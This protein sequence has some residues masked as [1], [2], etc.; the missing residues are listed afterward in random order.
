M[1]LALLYW[2]QAARDRRPKISRQWLLERENSLAVRNLLYLGEA[3]TS[4]SALLALERGATSM[5]THLPQPR[6][7]RRSWISI[8]NAD[9]IIA[10]AMVAAGLLVCAMTWRPLVSDQ[11][12]IADQGHAV[13]TLRPQPASLTTSPVCHFERRGY[14]DPYGHERI[15]Q[16][17]VCE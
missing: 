7:T 11:L 10:I 17:S 12:L 6:I 14:L 16:V 15:R 3:L 8:K 13:L 1:E 2:R 9:V 4:S 5:P